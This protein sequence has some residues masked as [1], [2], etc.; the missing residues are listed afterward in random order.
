[1]SIPIAEENIGSSRFSIAK[2]SE[3]K[4]S[5]I[6]DVSYAIK[7]I[8]TTDLSDIHLLEDVTN[9]LASKI[10]NTWRV[11]SK[12]VN[13]TKHSKSWWNEE[14]SLVL[15]NYKTTR[16]LENWKI[17]KSKVKTT[18][19]SFFNNKIQEITNKKQGPWKL[20]NWVNKCKLPA[21]KAI[22][23]NDQQCLN[24]NNL[25]NAL[26]STFN[27]ALHHQ[28]DV[29]I[30][31]EIAEKL[32]FSWPLFS[33]EEFRIAIAN[34]NNTSASGPDKLSWS[35]LKIILND[36]ECLDIIIHIANTCIELG[37]WP[38]HFKRSTTVIIPKP[39]KKSYDS[40]KSFRP[41]VLLNTVDK[42]IEK[43]IGERLQFSTAAN[44]FI[45]LSQLSGLKFKSTID[46][47]IVLMHII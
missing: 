5:F 10:K 8:D 31:D 46:M 39:N 26:H 19:Q 38:L 17:F 37:Y 20:M 25:W 41:I 2:N 45:H 11:N 4:A 18:K 21:I 29:K 42:L 9:T 28:V 24:I 14:C 40:P 35:H 43:V 27:T 47:G 44:D 7:N 30:L 22:K 6:K 3:E 34:C 33:R 1:M 15:S 32:T 13:I 23:Y 12:Q 16:S 36:D